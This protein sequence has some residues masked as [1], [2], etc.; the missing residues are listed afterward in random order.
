MLFITTANDAS[1]IPAPLYDRMDVI[2]L[3][4]YTA[5]E[6]WHIAKEHLIGKQIKANGLKSAQIRFSDEVIREIIDGY[7]REAGVR[8]LEREIGRICRKAA[9][10]IVEGKAKRVTVSSAEEF[11]G[12]RKFK[13]DALSHQDEIGVVNGLAWTSAGGEMLP[14]EVAI[15]DGTGKIELTGS[16]GDVMKESARIAISYARAHAREWQI[17]RDFYK[18]K[19]IHI[20]AP[21]GAVPKDGPSAGIAMTTALI[22]ALTGIPVRSDVA[23]TG[24]IS[25]RGRVLPIGGLREKSMAAYTHRIKTVII[26]GENV[27]DLEEVDAA[28][29][30]GL[31]FAPVARYEEVLALA[32]TRQPDVAVDVIA[33]AAEPIVP[34]IVESAR[35]P[36]RDRS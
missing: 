16:L 10:R 17:E 20:H 34:P 35:R 3:G 18:T 19:D 13:P 36:C 33:D 9:C 14:I 23:M 22:S 26:P 21:E 25:L 24:E 32:L 29:K 4:S 8:Q 5:E 11:L 28:V 7:T 12:T 15:L 1:A 6:K 30:A 27:P 31:K 2:K